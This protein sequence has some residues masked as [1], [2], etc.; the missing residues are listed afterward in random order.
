MAE[1]IP[2][3]WHLAYICAH[4]GCIAEV[5][6]GAV[7]PLDSGTTLTCDEC[8]EATVVDLFTPAQREKMCRQLI[9]I[10][11]H[12]ERKQNDPVYLCIL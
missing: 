11:E 4:C 9:K 1:E 2:F 7:E 12:Q 8:G 10:N 3:T 6:M 5:P